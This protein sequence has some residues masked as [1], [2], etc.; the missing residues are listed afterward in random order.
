M[1]LDCHHTQ[2][3]RE[4]LLIMY[5]LAFYLLVCLVCWTLDSV[6]IVA[7]SLWSTDKGNEVC[8]YL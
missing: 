8:V 1:K 6:I 3:I 2:Y 4:M 5:K 7:L